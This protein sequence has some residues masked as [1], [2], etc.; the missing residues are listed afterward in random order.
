M[1]APAVVAA[2]IQAGASLLGGIFGGG[3]DSELDLG[4]LRRQAQKHGFNPLTVLGATGGQGFHRTPSLASGQL[5]AE[6]AARGVDTYFNTQSA[7]ADRELGRLKI[8][9]AREELTHMREQA[10]AISGGRGF[11]YDLATVTSDAVRTQETSAPLTTMDPAR[12]GTASEPAP[13]RDYGG[14]NV[15]VES[16]ETSY[17]EPGAFIAG[18]G[19][20]ISDV[21]SATREGFRHLFKREAWQKLGE[22]QGVTAPVLTG[23][24]WL[25]ALKPHWMDAPA[26]T[27]SRKRTK[28]VQP[29]WM[30]EK[31]GYGG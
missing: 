4:R 12:K 9:L 30:S 19:N 16:Y 21:Y 14:R 8:E 27:S 23:E 7:E 5:L 1:V 6:A 29:G 20:L 13:R 18:T 15:D 17:D 22:H 3:N 10:S 11:G 28:D 2:G 31:L 24:G 26:Y 25:P